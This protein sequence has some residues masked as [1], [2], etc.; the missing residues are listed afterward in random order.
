[1]QQPAAVCVSLRLRFGCGGN[2]LKL[3][4]SVNR[5]RAVRYESLSSLS[6]MLSLLTLFKDLV[7]SVSAGF[8]KYFFKSELDNAEKSVG[9]NLVNLLILY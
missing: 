2:I 9:F 4:R 6:T 5:S 8:V 1:M 7:F 3:S